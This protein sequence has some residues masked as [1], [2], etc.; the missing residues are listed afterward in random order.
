M[1]ITNRDLEIIR[2][3][4]DMKF[5]SIPDIH[6]KF[7]KYRNDGKV[8]ESEWWA[9]ERLRDLVIHGFLR[10]VR[11]RFENKCYYMGTTN[12]Y[13]FATNSISIDSPIAKPINKIDIRTFEHDCHVL[14]ARLLLEGHEKVTHW[15]SDRQLKESYYDYFTRSSTR[16]FCP[17]GVY[18]SV[19]GKLI[20]FE[21]ELAQKTKKRYQDKIRQYISSIG[22]I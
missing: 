19:N 21:Y 15:Q 7:F 12:G 5:A 11:F 2:F 22:R 16:D 10:S 13:W 1:K 14:S 18:K 17:D 8:S 4:L 20:A 9:R 6:T 3:V